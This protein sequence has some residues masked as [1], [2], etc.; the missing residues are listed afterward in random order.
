MN[1]LR[2]WSPPGAV[3]LGFAAALS[4]SSGQDLV[5]QEAAFDEGF[6]EVFVQRLPA[7][8]TVTTLVDERGAVFIPVRPILDLV[9]IPVQS[10]GDALAL[11]WPPGEWRTVLRLGT[12]VLEVGGESQAVPPEELVVRDGQPFVSARVLARLLA[13]RVDVDW[14]GLAIVVSENPEFPATRRL[15]REARRERERLTAERLRPDEPELRFVPKTGGAAGTWGLGLTGA[16]GSYRGALRASVGGSVLGGATEMGG[17]LSFGDHVQ[18]AFGE[19]YLLYHRVF[20]EG[21]LVRQV[22]AGS[23]LSRG[24]VARRIV[25]VSLTNEPFTTPRY[26]A[27]ALIQPTVPVGWEYEVY[28]GDALVG[29]SSGDNPEDLR[30]PLNYGNTPVRVRMIGPAGQERVEE[31]LYV[32]PPDRLPEGEWRYNLGFGPCRDPGCDSYG[33]A[34]VRRG[35][36][37]WLTTGL[38][39]DR[40]DP[41]EGTVDVR[42]YGYVGFTPANGLNFDVQAQPGAFFRTS[43]DLATPGSGVYGASYAWTRPVGDAPTLD[44][45]YGQLTGN[46][47]VNVFGGR[48]VAA[49]L[50]YRGQKRTSVE[51]WQLFTATTVR[52]SYVSAEFEAGLQLRKIV[53]ARVFTPL[54]S[55]YHRYLADL[56]VSAGMG[57]TSRGPELLELGASFR[58]SASGSVNLDVRFRRGAS[59]LLSIGFVGR[60]PQGYFQARAARGSGAGVFLSADGGVA[61]DPEEG[62]VPLPFQSL[63]R[64]GIRGRVFRDLDGDGVQGPEDPPAAAVDILVQGERV[65]TDP[66]GGYRTWSLRP[67]DVAT[68]AVD[69]LSIDPSWVPAPRRVLLRPSPNVF[70]EV[71]LPL[72]QTREVVGRVQLGGA[73]PQPLGGVRVEILD[74]GGT[75]LATQRTF[76]DGVFY[77]QRIPPG[78]YTVR[79]APSSAEALGMAEVPT[80]PLTVAG[81]SDAAVELPT[82]VLVPG[83]ND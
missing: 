80:M 8:I 60:R 53:T 21:M 23:V 76:S 42:T 30:A 69:S 79:I 16:A 17:T 12:R 59:P 14:A 24:P 46:V 50:Q 36:T 27:D 47:P 61:W 19:S 13:A 75:V 63:G 4:V 45:W 25:G 29:V 78:R 64:S 77:V 74:E 73:D 54:G 62:V 44:G 37:P 10:E 52:R 1:L 6:F 56:A 83:G 26:F 32:I 71:N 68:V 66:E 3:A 5:A 15:E 9:G 65:T 33:Y 48:T 39:M 43:A 49:R 70:N 31:L 41:A 38:G 7:R 72:L 28:Q 81:G 51:S 18:D 67:Y 58:P 11:E 34:E 35:M 20:P 22:E 40:I 2:G 57:A 82:W 55:S